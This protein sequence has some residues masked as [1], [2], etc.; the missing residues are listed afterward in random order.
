ML[1]LIAVVPGL[2]TATGSF[3]FCSRSPRF[4]S[5]ERSTS[6]MFSSLGA[7]L[8]GPPG[9]AWLA[10]PMVGSPRLMLLVRTKAQNLL[11]ASCH[12][13]VM[14]ACLPVHPSDTVPDMGQPTFWF[15]CRSLP[16]LTLLGCI[17]SHN[18]PPSLK[19]PQLSSTCLVQPKRGTHPRG[20]FSLPP[21]SPGSF[22]FLFTL[23]HLVGWFESLS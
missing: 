10:R 5:A 19:S 7:Y 8:L 23:F 1:G 2:W 16:G 21:C 11:L 15:C 17:G 20:W 22:S 6:L 12:V 9:P 14:L 3:L 13:P 18:E 4:W